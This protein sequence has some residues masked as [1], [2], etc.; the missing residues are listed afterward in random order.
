MVEN[1]EIKT[2][3][4]RSGDRSNNVTNK[5]L[6]RPEQTSDLIAKTPDLNDSATISYRGPIMETVRK[7]SYFGQSFR[8]TARS[9]WL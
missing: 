6:G 3:R 2:D 7:H 9:P 5:R 4:S 1:L 8:N